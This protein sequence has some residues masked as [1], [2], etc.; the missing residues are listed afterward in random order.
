MED[1]KGVDCL[2]KSTEELKELLDWWL[3]T[4]NLLTLYKHPCIMLRPGTKTKEGYPYSNVISEY[5][6]NINIIEQYKNNK[7]IIS[8][9]DYYKN[10]LMPNHKPLSEDEINT[11]SEQ[12]RKEEWEA[13][14]FLNNN[15]LYLGKIIDY[16]TPIK[17][18]KTDTAGKI[19]ILAYNKEGYITLIEY[20]RQDNPENLV[21]AIL[22]ICT[23]FY[24]IDKKQLIEEILE[25]NTE[26]KIDKEPKKCV[27]LYK[28]SILHKQYK[29]SVYKLAKILEVEVYVLQK[30][31]DGYLI[32]IAQEFKDE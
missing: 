29:E 10:Y 23:Y 19:D 15:F 21:R 27:L 9:H 8:R 24:Q 25:K 16:Q 31:N 3:K 28:D 7:N 18:V 26:Y 14:S 13:R 2:N 32:E 1:L 6:I 17:G 30:I 11:L 4:D 5:L 12:E 22:E 20:K